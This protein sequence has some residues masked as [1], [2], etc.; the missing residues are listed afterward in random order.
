MADHDAVSVLLDTTVKYSRKKPRKVYLYKK[1][2]MG[3]LRVELET[4]KDTFL[5]SNPMERTI[6]ENW[7]SFKTN[8]FHVMDNCIPQKH[9]S[10]WQD[11]PW[12]NSGIKRLIRKKKRLWNNAKRTDTAENWQKFKVTRKAVKSSMKK[13][14]EEYVDGIL[15]DTT[16]DS[17]R[18]F[19][20]FINSQ[21]K[22]SRGI[23]ILKTDGGLAT[24]NKAKG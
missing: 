1:G 23:P 9:I 17:Q 14:Y 12:M 19:W 4:Y 7:T 22:D 15:E 10:S 18:K 21:K 13:A 8:L 2:D 11:S 24:N 20:Q 5:Q 16:P 6:E 3:K